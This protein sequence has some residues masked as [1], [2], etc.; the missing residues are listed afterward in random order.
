MKKRG[1]Y[2]MY[3]FIEIEFLKL[4]R[5]KIFLLTILGAIFPSFIL[6]LS[7]KFGEFSQTI[8]LETFLHQVYMYTSVIFV[9]MLFTIIISYLFGREYN[10]HTLKTVLTAPTSRESFILGKYIMFLVWVLIIT[11]VTILSALAFG[12][13]AGITEIT[14]NIVLENFKQ[15]LLCNMLLYLTFTPLVFITMKITNLVPAIIGG[16]MLTF[17][18]M[19]IT[20][21]KYGMYF[22]WSCPYLITSGEIIEYTTN[23]IPSYL[24]I[25]ATFVI[26]LAVS[27]IYFIKKDVPL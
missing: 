22:P 27:Y 23:Y 11:V 17:T 2:I 15:L 1:D 8:S 3:N 20:G 26:G 10:E 18:N 25:L 9:I 14:M 12:Y 7:A 24:I 4:K 6:F 5:S 21:S 16:A 13:L 19:I